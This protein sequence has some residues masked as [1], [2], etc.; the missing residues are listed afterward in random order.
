M[1]WIYSRLYIEEVII[2]SYNKETGMY[3]GYIYCIMNK[4]NGK[5][6][7]GQTIRT[8]KQRW[9]DHLRKQKYNKDNQY[10]YTAMQKYGKENFSI[11]EIEIIKCESK[12]NLLQLL[13]EKEVYYINF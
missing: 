5:K 1:D 6:Y 13:N 12:D 2:I 8:I 11:Q 4:V 9:G 3:E 10:L 7:I